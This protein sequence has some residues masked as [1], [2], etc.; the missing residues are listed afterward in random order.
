MH[1]L[2]EP[3]L[4]QG[5]FLLFGAFLI[6]G[7]PGQLTGMAVLESEE[8]DNFAPPYDAF[9]GEQLISLSHEQAD[10][11]TFHVEADIG[12]ET[13]AIY[14]TIYYY[15]DDGWKPVSI[16]GSDWIK[17]SVSVSIEDAYGDIPLREGDDLFV[18]AWL[19]VDE[20]ETWRCGCKAPSDCGHWHLQGVDLEAGTVQ[21]CMD[22]DGDGY[23]AQA[24]SE[25]FFNESDC[26]DTDPAV[27]PGMNETV[28]NGKDD[29]CDSGTPDDDL[30]GDGAFLAEDCDDMNSSLHPMATET[31]QDGVDQDCDGLDAECEQC[32]EG[33]IPLTGCTCAGT[34]SYQGF[35]CDNTYQEQPC[36]TPEV[37]FYDGFESGSGNTW[38][39]LN[40]YA[41]VNGDVTY[42]GDYSLD[43][44]YQSGDL[45]SDLRAKTS[46]EEENN[47]FLR[48]FVY[49]EEDFTQP[50]DGVRLSSLD[51]AVL[52]ARQWQGDPS[53]ARL[54]VGVG[55]D[56]S[57]A[58]VL[59]NGRWYCVEEEADASTGTLRTWVD[60]SLV[61]ERSVDLPAV[62][63]ELEFG[64]PYE[65][66]LPSTPIHVYFDN[67][68]V[69]RERVGCS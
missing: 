28:Y 7:L 9:T 21:A 40:P 13:S 23:G 45:T 39:Y 14:S 5:L 44:K 15:T 60:D 12:S 8:T 49:F 59:S 56:L 46:L 43:L 34:P 57:D 30:D 50:V 10:K 22:S 29:D 27:N 54:L 31:C 1:R 3:V 64:G 65:G 20:N 11:E 17:N 6:L 2:H 41:E 51:G 36:G 55:D 66:S 47:V 24:S 61:S 32:G 67:V 35:C 53:K 26:D 16:S 18:G 19:C 38:D 58:A 25:C 37:L 68:V 4:W 33:D 42:A 63:D 52:E 48:Y 69:S 62:V